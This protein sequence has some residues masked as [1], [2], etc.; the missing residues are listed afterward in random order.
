MAN[1]KPFKFGAKATRAE[2]AKEWADLARQAEDLGY[3]S[4]H[5]DDHFSGMLATMPAVMAAAAATT[6]LKVGPLVAGNDFRNPVVLARE[7]ATIDLLA[8]GRLVLGLGAGWLKSDYEIAG[9]EQANARTRIARLAETVRICRGVWSAEPFSFA[10]SHFRVAEVTGYPKPVSEIPILIGGG[11]REIL[12]L[13]AREADIVGLNPQIVAR[14]VNPRSMATAAPD[15]ID[16]RIEWIREAAG[17]R[18]DDLELQ[19][20]VMVAAVT[21]KPTAVTDRLGPV[22]GLSHEEVLASPHFQVGSLADIS[23]ELQRI[24]ARWGI[25]YFVFQ[26]DA[27][28][29]VA[30]IVSELQ[31]R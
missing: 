24:R 11:G 4:F 26:P 6:N 18:F 3:T 23:E 19:L 1:A 7:S 13:A 31:G 30:P 2:S 16:E 15:V 29:P 8:D 9:I 12:S 25:S 14:S 5:V 17:A 28:L 27:T 10:G 22:F 21:D 20:H